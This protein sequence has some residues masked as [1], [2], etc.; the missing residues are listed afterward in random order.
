MEFIPLVATAAV[1]LRALLGM[2]ESL[3]AE[4]QDAQVRVSIFFYDPADDDVSLNARLGNVLATGQVYSLSADLS[5]E[6]ISRYFAPM[7]A[8]LDRTTAGPPLPDIGP[9]AAVYDAARL[10]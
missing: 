10:R 2:A 3:R 9:M 4:L 6:R 5:R 7:L 8:A 1:L